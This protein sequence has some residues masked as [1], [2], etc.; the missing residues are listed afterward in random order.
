[1]NTKI[2]KNYFFHIGFPKTASTYLH[3]VLKKSESVDTLFS[4]D[5][6]FFSFNKANLNI[7]NYESQFKNEDTSIKVDFDHSLIMDIEGL[8]LLNKNFPKSKILVTIRNPIDFVKSNFLY[9]ISQGKYS[10]T[11][12]CFDNFIKNDRHKI[13]QSE[14]LKDVLSIFDR[15]RVLILEYE[16]LV[17]NKVEFLNKIECFLGIK[18][19]TLEDIGQVNV[20]RVGRFPNVI[21]LSLRGINTFLRRNLPIFHTKIKNSQTIKSLIF[22]DVKKEKYSFNNIIDA[23]TKDLLENDLIELN[24]IKD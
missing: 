24:L 16:N 23:D 17:S 22:I 9:Q 1:M 14:R 4:K 13:I 7:K 3:Q 18:K 10:F 6:D 15:K 2:K 19:N 8:N 21:M 5:L 12:K 20:A 11:K